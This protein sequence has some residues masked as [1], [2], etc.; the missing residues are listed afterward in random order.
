MK[1][2]DFLSKGKGYEKRER[3]YLLSYS[4]SLSIEKLFQQIDRVLTEGEKERLQS[5]IEERKKGRPIQYIRKSTEF[6]SREF[7]IDERVFIPRPE[8]EILVEEA[9][10]ILNDRPQP[11]LVLDMGTG[12]GVIGVTIAKETGAHVLLVDISP[13][14]LSVAK[15]NLEIHEI[16]NGRLICSDLFSAIRG[17]RSFDMIL[18]NLPYVTEREFERL[19]R[20]VKDYEPIEA[21]L[22]G[23]SGF[24]IYER[25]LRE[26][27]LYLKEDGYI[28]FEIGGERQA[29]RAERILR[30]GGFEVDFKRDLGGKKRV[31]LAWR[32]L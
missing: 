9:I 2:K 27:V 16:K 11:S 10:R 17:S 1:V 32:N 5:L 29:K 12:S 3:L 25:F 22:G 30:E 23:R 15:K 6:F 7:F 26:S 24:E 8:T 13:S 14:A 28:L 19:P 4:L 31:V 20:M 18:A 21:L